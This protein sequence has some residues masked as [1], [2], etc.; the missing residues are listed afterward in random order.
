MREKVILDYA[1]STGEIYDINNVLLFTWPSLQAER[2]KPEEQTT[3]KTSVAD[4]IKL[5]SAGF[6]AAEII[7]LTQAGLV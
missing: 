4:L 5:K 2:Y 1:P 6:D 7:E 3:G